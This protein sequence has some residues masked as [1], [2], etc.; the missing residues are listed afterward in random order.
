MRFAKLRNVYLKNFNPASSCGRSISIA[1]FGNLSRHLQHDR[2]E[3][4]LI[5]DVI[6]DFCFEYVRFK[7]VE[8]TALMSKYKVC[9][10]EIFNDVLG[11]SVSSTHA[12]G[13]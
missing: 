12:F 5:F 2:G 11:H 10:S 1:G 6:V 8:N 3:H 13:M 9:R 4:S 7:E